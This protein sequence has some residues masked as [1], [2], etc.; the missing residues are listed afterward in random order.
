MSYKPSLCFITCG[1]VDDGKSTLIG[2]MLLGADQVPTDTL[3]KAMQDSH[4]HGR[5][6]GDCD[7]AFLLD[8][9]QDER[10]QGITIDV[11]YRYFKSKHRQ[12]TVA[13]CPGHEQY[14]RNMVTGASTADAAVI[15]VDASKG[16]LRQTKRHAVLCSLLGIRHVI[17]TVNKMD[18]VD[19]NETVYRDIVDNFVEFAKTLAFDSVTTIP[20]SAKNDVNI[21]YNASSI[22]PWYEGWC[23]MDWLDGLS[24]QRDVTGCELILPL[25]GA[26]HPTENFRG[27]YGT[28]AAGIVTVGMPVRDVVTRVESVITGIWIGDRAVPQADAGCAVMLTT[29]DH[30]DLPRGSVLVSEKSKLPVTDCFD[31]TLIWFDT[32]SP[33]VNTLTRSFSDNYL[34]KSMTTVA[35]TQGIELTHRVAVEQGGMLV[36]ALEDSRVWVND[37]VGTTI[38]LNKPI[39]CSP[40]AHNTVAGSFI[41]IDRLTN[42]TVAAGLITHIH[43]M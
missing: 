42:A 22:C 41:L 39:A 17:L 23:L 13:D 24:V 18:L 14:T 3:N 32:T 4:R 6:V 34:L 43:P 15:L 11:A 28:L 33:H 5:P 20:I 16:L 31:A 8:G 21:F 12:Y 27:Y 26:I 29:K 7:L 36:P 40:Y 2:R 9:L 30:V 1:S 37:I 10:D 19:W 35:I 38:R 25:Q